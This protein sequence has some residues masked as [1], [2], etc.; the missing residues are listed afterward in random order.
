[1]A[2]VLLGVTGGIAAY[3]ACELVRLLV[4]A[5]H[6]VIPLVT[7][8][9]ERFVRAETFYALA[10][11]SPSEDPYPHLERADLLVVAPLTA[12][13]LAKLAHG[14]ADSV[15]TEA[16]LAHRGPILVAPAM[17]PRM[18]SHPA[19]Q[20]N[21]ALLRERGVELIG[22]EEGELAEGGTGV[23][24]M[25]EP[26][27][28]A[29]RCEELLRP[30]PGSLAGRRVLV[31]AGGTREPLD[32]VRFLGNRSSGRMGVALAEEA[33]R[34]G[35]EVTLLAANLTVDPPTGV[36]VVQAP[37]ADDLAR[38]ALARRDADIVVMAAAVADYRPAEASEAK[39][40]KDDAPWEVRLEPTTDVLRELGAQRRNGGVL[41][42]FAADE[43]EQGLA[44]AREKRNRKG[45]DLIVYN[46][47]GRTDVGFDAVENE[48]VVISSGGERQIP[49]APKERVAAAI[50]DEAEAL[51]RERDGR[52]GR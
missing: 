52:D 6:E 41:V 2:R 11:R 7:P 8:A 33:R 13:T 9:A 43:G 27:A 25:A 22:P 28:I 12:N 42:G 44:R 5:G 38:E 31:T 37:T 34:R 3:K 20:A 26:E 47:V 51:L 1:V 49:K 24:R 40:P 19:T 14:L 4:R 29:A 21:V 32:L 23:G 15:L 10:R 30:A 17:N 35:A 50:L 39:R 16:A 46:D 48:V 18:W 45:A 36:E